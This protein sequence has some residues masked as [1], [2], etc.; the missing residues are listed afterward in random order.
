MQV[1]F[2]Q[3]SSVM[4]VVVANKWAFQNGLYALVD[5]LLL[6]ESQMSEAYRLRFHRDHLNKTRND[7][8]HL[9]VCF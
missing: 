3:P 7:T 2:I 5:D 6:M 9:F 8:P 4:N 1:S